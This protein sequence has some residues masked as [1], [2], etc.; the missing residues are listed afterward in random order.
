[1]RLEVR[2][3]HA[4]GRDPLGR[5]GPQGRSRQ[6]GETRGFLGTPR[7]AAPE[8]LGG[9]SSHAH[10]GCCDPHSIGETKNFAQVPCSTVPGGACAPAQDLPDAMD[11]S[12]LGEARIVAR[13]CLVSKK[14]GSARASTLSKVTAITSVRSGSTASP[15]G[16]V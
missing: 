13:S 9:Q 16:D 7:E 10:K 15:G 8:V 5:P 11:S 1:M 3:A 14:W 2:R 4:G 12:C 6:A